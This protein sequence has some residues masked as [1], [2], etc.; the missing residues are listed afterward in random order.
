MSS[1]DLAARI[2]KLKRRKAAAEGAQAIRQQ[3]LATLETKLRD[4]GFPV[5]DGETAVRAELARRQADVDTQ[6]AAAEEI[7]AQAETLLDQIEGY[8]L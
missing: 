3:E 1:D 5:D 7:A 6:R 8:G 4:A 2:E